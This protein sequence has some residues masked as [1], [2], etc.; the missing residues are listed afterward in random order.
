[1]ARKTRNLKGACRASGRRRPPGGCTDRASTPRTSRAGAHGRGGAEGLVAD[2][3]DVPL[4][5]DGEEHQALQEQGKGLVRRD[6]DGVGR[7]DLD[8]LDGPHVAVLRRLLGLVDD[9]VDGILHVLRGQG[10]AV[11]KLDPAAQLELPHGVGER[12][13]GGGQGRLVLQLG[14]PVEQGVEH[15]D[16]DEDAHAL[17]V[18]VRVHGGRMGGEGDGQGVLGL[19]V[20]PG[21]QPQG[22]RQREAQRTERSTCHDHSSL[23]GVGRA[24]S[25]GGL[26]VERSVYHEGAAR[27]IAQG[28]GSKGVMHGR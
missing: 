3:L 5:D 16:V 2:L 21:D 18:H 15:V 4:G 14:V 27:T 24:E 28:R 6:V 10:I 8:F 11:V 23:I 1:M 20:R 12:L 7:D 17:E 25:V 22:Q 26:A 9:P 19:G 13:P